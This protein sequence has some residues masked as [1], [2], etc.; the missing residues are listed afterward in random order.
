MDKVREQF[1]G[2]F[3]ENIDNTESFELI[4]DIYYCNSSP[5]VAWRAYQQAHAEQQAV[6][7]ELK[8]LLNFFVN[9]P[10]VQKREAA[11]VRGLPESMNP[12]CPY[13]RAAK[14]LQGTEQHAKRKLRET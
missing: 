5:Q 10:D 2:W 11:A 12:N 9:A 7:D 6:I 1:E 13:R 8:E 4:D 3:L 14:A